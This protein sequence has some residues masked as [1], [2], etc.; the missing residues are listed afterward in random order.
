MYNIGSAYHT[1]CL[2]LHFPPLLSAPAFSTPA[3]STLAVCSR[4]F[5]SCIFHPCIFDRIAFSNPA[6]SVPPPQSSHRSLSCN[7]VWCK[8][9][10]II[11]CT[12][13]KTVQCPVLYALGTGRCNRWL[14]QKNL[15]VQCFVFEVITL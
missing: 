3:F 15:I 13:M 6:F 1:A 11:N 12:K 7:F 14:F 10:H 4:I 8:F 5:H 9:G 2:L